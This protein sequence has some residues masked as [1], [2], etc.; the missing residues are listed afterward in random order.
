MLFDEVDLLDVGGPYEV[1]LTASRLAERAG[2]TPPFDVTT[3]GP[4]RVTAYG[5]LGLRPEAP[6]ERLGSVDLLVVPGA[7]A[8]EAAATPVLLRPLRAAADQAS[9]VASVCTGA[10]LLAKMDLLPDSWTTHWED[11]DALRAQAGGHGDS[12]PRWVDAGEVVTSGGLSSGIA[13]ALHLVDR[14]AGRDLALQTATQIEYAWDPGGAD[15][16]TPS[17]GETA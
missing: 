9:I 17:H 10:F 16:V 5:G 14:L 2:Q 4:E 13:M 15:R 1:F 11:I 12:A 3:V 6:L 8:I 7:V